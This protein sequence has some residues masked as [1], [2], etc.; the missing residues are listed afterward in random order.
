VAKGQSIEPSSEGR[1]GLS[2]FDGVLIVGGGLI[3]LFVAFEV[4][5]FIAGVVWFLVKLIVVVAL[6]GLVIKLVFRRRS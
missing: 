2:V 6:I 1:T 4:L 5:G 3:A